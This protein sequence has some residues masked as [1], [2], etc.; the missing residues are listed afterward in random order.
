MP[1]KG[2]YF[3]FF[4]N[5]CAATS[6]QD[7]GS[8]NK[9]ASSV[10]KQLCSIGLEALGNHLKGPK[11]HQ[12]DTI[13]SAGENSKSIQRLLDGSVKHIP[14]KAGEFFHKG[15]NVKS[16][17]ERNSTSSTNE[18]FPSLPA[19]R[20]KSNLSLGK[21]FIESASRSNVWKPDVPEFIP[22]SQR[23]AEVDHQGESSTS[24]PSQQPQLD[25][26]SA[27]T[28]PHREKE[29]WAEGRERDKVEKELKKRQDAEKKI[30]SKML[31]KAKKDDKAISKRK[32]K[33]RS[34]L[35]PT[36]SGSSAP[37]ASMES[38]S[39]AS[40]DGTVDR[41][42]PF[43]E[44]RKRT[45]SRHLKPKANIS[46]AS[47]SI[48]GRQRIPNQPKVGP[49]GCFVLAKKATPKEEVQ[50]QKA[51][52]RTPVYRR[53]AQSK[54]DPVGGGQYN[55]SD[56][57]SFTAEASPSVKSGPKD[58]RRVSTPSDSLTRRP[59]IHG[60]SP[61]Q[62]REHRQRLSKGQASGSGFS[63]HGSRS[64]PVDSSVP[65]QAQGVTF[66]VG[67]TNTGSGSREVRFEDHL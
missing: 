27:A 8:H 17:S 36:E 37:F 22:T 44:K 28:K 54:S 53:R 26:G 33:G 45:R 11:S 47:D 39:M 9:Q 60:S 67:L 48:D 6:V 4:N 42:K 13:Y 40:M 5:H 21:G 24:L 49:V 63:D 50:D 35:A 65:P 14:G 51:V 32:R 61:S 12:G 55:G 46:L 2:K 10:L 41:P 20:N 66:V 56:D 34:H 62:G 7:D 1:L 19:G 15:E 31:K 30:G 38:H 59:I 25:P 3:D 57:Q 29:T 52:Y 64:S 58:Y 16:T 23:P 18:A 43:F